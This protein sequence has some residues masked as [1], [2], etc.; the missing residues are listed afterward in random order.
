M[1]PN[2]P[3]GQL[4]ASGTGMQTVIALFIITWIKTS[5]SEEIFFRGFICTKLV[6]RFGFRTGNLLQATIF[7]LVHLFLFYILTN[8]GIA[9]SIL[10]FCLSGFAGYAIGYVKEKTGNGS[11]VPGWIAHGLGNMISYTILVY[12]M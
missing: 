3:I 12:F 1:L 5:L 2:T 10:A 8:A 7:G 9:F 11:T 4:R 6:S